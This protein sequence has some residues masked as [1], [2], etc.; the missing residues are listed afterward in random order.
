MTM[1]GSEFC[2]SPDFSRLERLYIKI[3]GMP[4]L[5][6]RIRAWRMIPIIKKYL[7]DSCRVLDIGSGRGVFTIEMGKCL[8]QSEV[9]GVDLNQEKVA[10][11]NDLV[12]ALE[13][14][15]C[16]FEAKDIFDQSC[17]DKFDCIVAIDVLEHIED[18]LTIVKKIYDLLNKS[19]KL[20]VHVPHKYRYLFGRKRIN[21]DIEG[22]VRPGYLMEELEQLFIQA[23][24]KIIEKGYTYSSLETLANDLSYLITEGR[25]KRKMLYSLF[26][27]VLLAIS[28]LGR[29]VKPRRGSGVYIVGERS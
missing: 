2:Q 24:F 25:E 8:P 14:D 22:H 17:V 6:M 15:N 18:D 9:I 11:A 13:L 21:F 23:N 16:C 26:F 1:L 20:I 19:G 12:K 29:R 7:K 10:T 28:I 27:P 4:I 3:F 5:G